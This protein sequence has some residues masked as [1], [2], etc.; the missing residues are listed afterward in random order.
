[1]AVHI[2]PLASGLHGTTVVGE[3]QLG[4]AVPP[5][6]K[7]H[8]LVDGG[9]EPEPKRSTLSQAEPDRSRYPSHVEPFFDFALL[10]LIPD[11]QKSVV[12]LLAVVVGL[13]PG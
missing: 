6:D 9:P 12:V 2:P 5:V 13:F 4:W 10:I 8:H 11:E 3:R 1:M 7:V